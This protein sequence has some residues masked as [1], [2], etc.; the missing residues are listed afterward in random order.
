MVKCYVG[1]AVPQYAILCRTGYYIRLVNDFLSVHLVAWWIYEDTK[2]VILPKT[3]CPSAL[4]LI[5]SIQFSFWAVV[6]SKPVSQQFLWFP[7]SI[8]YSLN[9]FLFAGGYRCP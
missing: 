6:F 5:L 7:H 2:R 8:I 4:D 1:R 3:G 9:Q